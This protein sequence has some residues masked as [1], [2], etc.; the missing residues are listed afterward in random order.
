MSDKWNENDVQAILSNPI[1]LGLGPYPPTVDPEQWKSANVK[2]IAEIGP[3]A[4]IEQ[5]VDH[6]LKHLPHTPQ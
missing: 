2:M 3:E 5:L 4:Y 1:Y 6:L